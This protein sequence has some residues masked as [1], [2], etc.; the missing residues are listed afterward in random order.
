MTLEIQVLAWDRQQ[1]VAGSIVIIVYI[2]IFKMQVYLFMFLCR[3]D[4]VF[5]LEIYTNEY[6]CNYLRIAR[7]KLVI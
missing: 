1:D 3:F 4:Y 7:W 6:F 5:V 2:Y